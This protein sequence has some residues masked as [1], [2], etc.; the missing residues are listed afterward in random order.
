MTIR[1]PLL[2][3]GLLLACTATAADWPEF[4]GPNRDGLS[5]ET[6]LLQQWPQDGPPKVWTARNLGLGFGTPSVADGRIYGLGTRG[7]KDGIWALKEADG[8]ELWF[9]PFDNPRPTNQNNGPSGTPT[10]SG[11]KV[12]ALS[13]LGKL[14]CLDATSGKKVWDVD[15]VGRYGGRVEKWGYTESPLVDGDKVIG[16]PGSAS[17]TVAAWDKETGK[18]IWKTA[19]RGGAGGGGGYSS[20]IKATVGDLSMYVVLLGKGGGI[21]GLHVNTGKLLWQYTGGALGGTAQ[22]PTPIIKG[23]LV[24]FSTGYGGG[25]ALLQLIPDGEDRVTVKELKKY[26]GELQ[27]HHGGMV[28][29]GDHVY[30]G[31]GQNAGQPVCVELKTGE[32]QWG[33]AR[34]P[35]GGQ[36]S[37]AV[38][39]ADNRLYFR[40]QNR[41]LVLIEPSPEELKVVSSFQLPDADQRS[42]PQSWPHPVIANGKLYIRDQNL[43]YCY[44][45]TAEKN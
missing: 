41:M 13:S 11:G 4:R 15:Y 31:H 14:A 25:S 20:P 16:A 28:L 27:N 44:N 30:F 10:V 34:Y 40:Y 42:A 35:A 17:A 9:T 33:P 36:G 12:Y 32:I 1:L 6:G 38:L 26:R 22:I 8:S 18:E 39:Y 2:A 5:T 24:W 37:A 7:G 19:I 45:V 43:L 23:D 29:V 3:A 21:V